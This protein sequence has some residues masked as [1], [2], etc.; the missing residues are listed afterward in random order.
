M[1]VMRVARAF[2]GRNKLIK[3]TG[4]YHGHADMFLVKAGSGALTLGLPDSPGV[5]ASVT[6]DTLCVPF[7]DLEAVS[8]I[9]AQNPQ[10]IAGVILEP[11]V[12][13]AGY[14][15]PKPGFLQGLRKLCDQYQ[16]LLVFDEVM[17]GFRVAWG[18]A[19]AWANITPDLTTLGKVVGGGMP[20]AV[21]GGREDIMKW[22][23][24]A[25]PV[26]QAGT[27]SGNPVAVACG[28]KTLEILEGGVNFVQLER[29]VKALTTGFEKIGKRHNVPIVTGCRGGMF[30]FFF[31][32]KPVHSFEEARTTDV[33]LFKRFFSGMLD[34]G[35]YWPP[36]AFEAAF[37]SLA[38]TNEDIERTLEA[39]DDVIGA[40]HG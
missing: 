30:G 29:Q 6:A 19:Q 15:E 37:M 4:C 26:Y 24:P 35:I 14:I 22:V 36:S 12:G 34:R 17:T 21:Y 16:T 31:S 1:A 27:L 3:F 39:A 18:G 11:I 9:F 38:H 32:D 25:G 10:Q 40:L 20:L 13:N 5:N 23:A 2:T 8:Q 28:L 33:G 7:N